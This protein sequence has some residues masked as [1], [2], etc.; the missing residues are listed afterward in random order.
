[1]PRPKQ[2]TP[3]TFRNI[4]I[5][6]PLADR[7]DIE[8]FSDVEGRIP[9]GAYKEFFSNLLRQYFEQ[10]RKPCPRCNGTGVKGAVDV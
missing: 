3:S 7:L 5:P 6:K 4:A 9:M 1:M 2:A 8:L 10:K